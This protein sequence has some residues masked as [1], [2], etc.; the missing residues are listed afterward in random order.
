MIR[1]GDISDALTVLPMQA[2]ALERVGPEGA[3]VEVRTPPLH[4]ADEDRPHRDGHEV[5]GGSP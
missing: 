2:L 4:R 3:D 1:D 5:G